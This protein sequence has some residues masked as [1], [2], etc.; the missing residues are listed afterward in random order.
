MT[1]ILWSL[2]GAAAYG[3]SDFIGAVASR[4][5]SAWPVAFVSSTGGAVVA[6]LVAIA[7]P[8]HASSS[9]FAWAAFAGLGT[10]IGTAFLYRGLAAG[11]VGVVAPISAVAAAA[12]PVIVSTLSGERPPFLAWAGI[13]LALPGIWL[14]SQ[15]EGAT[16]GGSGVLDGVIA[17]IGFGIGFVGLGHVPESAGWWPLV[18]MNLTSA[19]AIVVVAT[20]MRAKVFGREPAIYLGLAGGVLAVLAMIGFV[21][22]TSHGLVSIAAVLVSL[23]PAVTIVLAVALLHERV[24]RIQHLG[25]VLCAGAV[26]LVAASG[27]G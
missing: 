25:F 4:R 14:V 3:V 8:G 17:G 1:A 26:A 15:E 11:R 21:L 27:R 6:A 9:H 16:F 5:S 19:A 10:G 18:I 2:L 12:L 20:A 24:H 22:A 13:A 23:Y 7:L